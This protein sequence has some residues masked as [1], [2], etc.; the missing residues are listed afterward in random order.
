MKA[1]E[2]FSFRLILQLHPAS[3]RKRFGQ[4]MMLDYQDALESQSGFHLSLDLLHSLMRQWSAA[5]VSVIW[6]DATPSRSVFLS[7]QNALDF[8][9]RLT[10]YELSRGFMLSVLLFS[11]FWYAEDPHRASL[12]NLLRVFSSMGPR[13]NALALAPAAPAHKDVTIRDVTIVDI[14]RGRFLAHRTV[15]IQDGII[16]SVVAARGASPTPE[17]DEVDG[18]GKFLIPGLWDMHAHITHTDVDF[19][20]YLANGVLGIRNMGG[21]QEQVFSWQA[22]L[23]D[24]SLLGPLA[25]VSGPILDGPKGPVQPASYGV[26]IANAEEARLEVDDLKARGA[27]FVKVYDGLSR[28]AYFAIAA[29]ANKV[30]L[31]FAGHVP[32]HITILEAVHAGQRSI[33]HGNRRP[34]RINI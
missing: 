3:F 30:G 32:G 16:L 20:M 27:D 17:A 19:P 13:D 26:R 21:V 23:K 25:F 7:G 6:S 2:R 4:E 5:L 33:E 22:K 9:T 11:A 34:W 12:G 31:P 24:G 29:E 8:Q 1:F 15:L 28:E 18:R 14:E 10:P